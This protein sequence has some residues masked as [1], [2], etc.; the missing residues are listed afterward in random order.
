MGG[1]ELV[2]VEEARRSANLGATPS[3]AA[4]AGRPG[5]PVAPTVAVSRVATV[6]GGLAAP[7]IAASPVAAALAA[8]L[9]APLV[10]PR[11]AHRGVRAP[12]SKRVQIVITQQSARIARSSRILRHQGRH[13]PFRK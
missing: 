12:E 8:P 2:P 3:L 5:A 9:A 11:G 13:G 7:P 10:C 4:L 6:P 1:A